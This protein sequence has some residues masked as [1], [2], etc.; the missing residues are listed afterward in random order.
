M[1]SLSVLDLSPVP[2]GSTPAQAIRDS[3]ALAR[4]ADAFGYERYWVSEHHAM[5]NLAG[6]APEMLMAAV[7][8]STARIRV[9]SGGIMLVNH[10]PLKVAEQAMTLEAL[11]PGRID[12]GL[13]RALGADAR[14][15]AALRSAGS[16]A[17][18][19]Y[20][21]L[22]SRW[23]S[24]AAGRAVQPDPRM[25]GVFA[26]P[27]GPSRPDLFLLVSSVDSAALA[28]RMGVGCVFAEFIAAN[29]PVPA[30]PGEALA[31]YHAAFRPGPQAAP[32]GGIALAAFAAETPA[33]A[34]RLDSVRRAWSL[35]FLTGR[36]SPFPSVEAALARLEHERH[37]PLLPLVIARAIVGDGAAVRAAL[38][39]KAAATGADGLF[40][41]S[42]GPSLEARIDSLRL[43]MAAGPATTRQHSLAE[44]DV[45]RGVAAA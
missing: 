17:F 31:A 18:P 36:R 40:V 9:G 45:A 14:A 25:D 19:V 22:L 26:Q 23:M 29:S 43:I 12:I 30:D 2:A 6:S 42:T 38:D 5:D 28:G 37:N 15:G 1:A 3:V 10:S 21:D 16:Q 4:A 11:A 32:W 7:A 27:K 13:G 35:D 24:E 33:E 41:M 34:E 39:A 44:P 8:V 20:F